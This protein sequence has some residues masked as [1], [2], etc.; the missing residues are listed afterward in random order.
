[1]SNTKWDMGY[2][3]LIIFIMF[4]VAGIIDLGFVVFGGTGSSF[5]NALINIGINAPFTAF[6]FGLIAGHLFFKMSP[7]KNESASDVKCNS[8]DK[9]QAQ[10]NH[11]KPLNT[12]GKQ[13]MGLD[14]IYIIATMV[15]L[16]AL[17][18]MDC[19]SGID[20]DMSTDWTRDK[21]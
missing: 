1:M 5:S 4:I 8:D 6:V 10:I 3:P 20:D 13:I 11:W 12:Q 17:F 14:G 18:L 21:K 19:L 9:N 16:I 7:K 2:A 15:A